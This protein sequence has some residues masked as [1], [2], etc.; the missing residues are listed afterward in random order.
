MKVIVISASPNKIGLTNT[1]VET[2]VT[3]LK[4]QKQEVETICLNDFN[5]ERCEACGPRGWGNCLEKHRCGKKDDFGLLREK[6]N[7]YEAI[8]LISPVYFWEMSEV[9][10]TFFDRYKRCEF[11]DEK[12]LS[13]N[14]RIMFVAAAGGSGRGTKECLAS[15]SYLA[16]FLKWKVVDY[17]GVTRANVMN[18]KL[19]MIKSVKKL[20]T[21]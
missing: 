18:K 12:V 2:C 19:Q 11:S 7:S 21:G 6:I 17:T 15:M 14:R 13:K 16:H 20:I 1:C 9:A 3:A 5:I 10:K 4:K 8:I